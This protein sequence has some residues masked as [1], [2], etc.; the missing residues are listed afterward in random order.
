M[1]D[2]SDFNG[3]QCF[4]GSAGVIIVQ[5]SK[6]VEGHAYSQ[7]ARRG[8]SVEEVI[9]AMQ[10]SSWQLAELGQPECCKD[11]AYG[12]EWNGRF[13]ET[14]QVHPI[15]V[16]ETDEIVVVTVYSYYF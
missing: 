15:F 6:T 10:T 13:Y 14:K 8:V 5:P 9:E 2:F 16:E 12:C 1:L 4:S 3:R 7:L 11:Y